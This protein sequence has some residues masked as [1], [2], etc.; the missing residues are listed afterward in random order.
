MQS[1]ICAHCGAPMIALQTFV[2]G[3]LTRAPPMPGCVP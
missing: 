1:F 3:G 2:R